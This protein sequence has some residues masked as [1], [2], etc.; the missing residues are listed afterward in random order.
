M[1]LPLKGRWPGPEAQPHLTA[2]EAW[3]R[4][5]AQGRL[6][7]MAICATRMDTEVIAHG[8]VQPTH[9]FYFKKDRGGEELVANI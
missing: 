1:A 8:H 4:R 2:R 3:K 5:G 6:G 7:S 9:V